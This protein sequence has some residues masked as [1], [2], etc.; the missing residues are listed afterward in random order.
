MV[1]ALTGSETTQRV[2]ATIA[3]GSVEPAIA[4]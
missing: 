2:V 3:S 1:A 4:R